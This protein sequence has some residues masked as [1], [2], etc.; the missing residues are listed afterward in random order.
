[1][2]KKIIVLITII[3]YLLW[4]HDISHFFRATPLFELARLE[5]KGLGTFKISSSY[6]STKHAQPQDCNNSQNLWNIYGLSNMHELGA[7]VPNKDLSNPLDLLLVQLELEPGRIENSGCE[8]MQWAAYSIDGSFKT[9][10][11]AFFAAYNVTKSFFIEAHLP[12]RAFFFGTPCFQDISPVDT[13]TPNIDSPLWQAFKLSFDAILERYNLCRSAGTEFGIGDLSCMLGYTH[14]HQDTTILDFVDL[15][16]KVGIIAPT[17]KKRNENKLFSLA[18]GNNGHTGFEISFD[19]AFGVYEWL[20]I[21]THINALGFLDRTAHIRIKTSPEQSGMIYLAKEK[22]KISRGA[23]LNAGAYF[24]ADHFVYG[25]SALL[26]Y[27]FT[28]QNN[29]TVSPCNHMISAH[30]ASDNEQLKRWK[31][32]I[33]HSSIEYDFSRKQWRYGP[34]VSLFYNKIVGGRRIFKTDMFGAE[35]GLNCIW[36]F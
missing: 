5:N 20:T 21:G 16:F 24:K 32:H 17:G 15:T 11:T 28:Q 18:M 4:G 6:G 31:M 1:M 7:G 3:P 13:I 29:S 8:T 35:C 10:D 26:G 14:S 25:F 34:S 23:I 2:N 30:I 12:M 9:I 27:S 33:I 36:K 22:A 19:T